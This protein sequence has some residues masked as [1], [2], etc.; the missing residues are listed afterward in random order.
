MQNEIVCPECGTKH[1]VPDERLVGYTCRFHNP[2]AIYDAAT[3]K[4]FDG[5]KVGSPVVQ[6]R[7]IGRDISVCA[8]NAIVA[9]AATTDESF[10]GVFEEVE[11]TPPAM[12]LFV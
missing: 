11:L 1:S 10:I 2:P 7:A 12:A 6:S 5:K 3:W 4:R 9:G 8:L